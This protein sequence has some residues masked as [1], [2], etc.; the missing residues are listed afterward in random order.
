LRFRFCLAMIPALFTSTSIR[1]N[2]W[3]IFDVV[4]L[5][6]MAVERAG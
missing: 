2:V 1:P 5:R 4:I 3:S 6:V